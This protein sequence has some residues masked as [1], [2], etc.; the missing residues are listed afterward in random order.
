MEQIGKAF[1]SLMMGLFALGWIG[2]AI[3]I[4]IVAFKFLSV[5]FEKDEEEQGAAMPPTATPPQRT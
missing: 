3:T 5:L 1:L 4:P 2:C